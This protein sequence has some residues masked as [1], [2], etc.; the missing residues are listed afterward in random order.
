MS[1][2]WS[3]IFSEIKVPWKSQKYTKPLSGEIFLLQG[4]Q[5]IETCQKSTLA[6][7]GYGNVIGDSFLW[8]MFP[9]AYKICLLDIHTTVNLLQ[10]T[11]SIIY[12]SWPPISAFFLVM[13]VDIT[14]NTKKVTWMKMSE[15]LFQSAN[16]EKSAFMCKFEFMKTYENC[17]SRCCSIFFITKFLEMLI[18]FW[19]IRLNDLKGGC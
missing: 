2:F 10:G 1:C 17:N 12:H 18:F 5:I 7:A 9:E 3:Q 8:N 19:G 15:K 14:R 16:I 6:V 13:L 4:L 11:H